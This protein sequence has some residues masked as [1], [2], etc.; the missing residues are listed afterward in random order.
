V[1][2]LDGFNPNVRRIIDEDTDDELQGEFNKAILEGLAID[3]RSGGRGWEGLEMEAGSEDDLI[4]L[5]YTSGTTARPKGVEY[6]HRGAY[7]G[8]LANVIESGLNTGSVL[9]N[10][11]ARY[12]RSIPLISHF[13]ED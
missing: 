10:G 13:S 11:R 12:V 5:A 3:Q 8:S 4:A 6:T 1:H 7:L 9:A 2:L